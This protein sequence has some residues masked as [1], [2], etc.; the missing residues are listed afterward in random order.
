MSKCGNCGTTSE[1]CTCYFSSTS[2]AIF[3]GN[4]RSYAGVNFRPT[5]V[6]LPRPYGQLSR[7]NTDQTIALSTTTAVVFDTAFTFFDGG[8]TDVVSFPTRLTAP[9]DGY[10]LAIGFINSSGTNDR[11]FIV[12]N[13]TTNLESQIGVAVGE[14]TTM[15]LINMVVGDYLELFV[16]TASSGGITIVRSDSTYP[17]STCYP[18]FWAQYVRAL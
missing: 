6:P 9:V 8:M 11:L 2:T 15:T 7:K 5:D 16:A 17:L 4:G 12:K 10:Y 1:G 13:G 18:H 14:R 3:T